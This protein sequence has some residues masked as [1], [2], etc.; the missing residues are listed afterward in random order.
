MNGYATRPPSRQRET[1]CDVDPDR[2]RSR[3]ASPEPE[4]GG[5][6]QGL[7]H[8]WSI[9]WSD[10]EPYYIAPHGRTQWQCPIK[11]IR[12]ELEMVYRENMQV[13]AGALRPLHRSQ[14]A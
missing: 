2:H 14:R 4:R 1:R 6:L 13:L 12:R 7:P 11:E 5:P 8:R 3:K 10:G 9:G